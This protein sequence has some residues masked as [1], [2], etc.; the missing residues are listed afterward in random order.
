MTSRGGRN[1]F[2][3]RAAR[4]GAHQVAS[5]SRSQIFW[6]EFNLDALF[7]QERVVHVFQSSITSEAESKMMKP[8]TRLPIERCRFGCLH[9]PQSEQHGPVGDEVGWVVGS[10][11][12][13]LEPEDAD[14]E[15]RIW[16]KTPSPLKNTPSSGISTSR[17]AKGRPLPDDLLNSSLFRDHSHARF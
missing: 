5:R 9:L 15:E 1:H 3:P 7:L 4:D 16:K 14:E 8:Q 12:D 17:V 6:S 11:C 10:L 13:R 2:H